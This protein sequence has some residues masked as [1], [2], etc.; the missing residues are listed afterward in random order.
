MTT[1][2]LSLGTVLDCCTLRNLNS[3]VKVGSWIEGR[4]K[5]RE[6]TICKKQNTFGKKK[7]FEWIFKKLEKYGGRRV[8][9]EVGIPPNFLRDFR[10]MWDVKEDI[11]DRKP[12]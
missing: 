4:R 8:C 1:D 5:Q 6:K 12:E 10:R 3:E 11:L 7:T 2:L 9:I